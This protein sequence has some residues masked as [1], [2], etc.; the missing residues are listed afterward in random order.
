MPTCP[1]VRIHAHTSPCL[2]YFHA[3]C[4]SMPSVLPCL[5]YFHAFCTSM[6]SVPPRLHAKRAHTRLPCLPYPRV[7]T[8]VYIPACLHAFHA[9]MPTPTRWHTR[10][11]V[12]MPSLPPF[13]YAHPSS[14]TPAFLH[15]FYTSMPPCPHLDT[16][17]CTPLCLPYLHAYI[18]MRLHALTCPY[19]FHPSIRIC[20]HVAI[21][22]STPLCLHTTRRHA[23]LHASIPSML[24]CLHAHTSPYLPYL[25]AM[26]PCT[27][28]RLPAQD[29]AHA[30]HSSHNIIDYGILS[31]VFG[32]RTNTYICAYHFV[33]RCCGG[34]VGSRCFGN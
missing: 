30:L 12:S 18:P 17:A 5:L 1:H 10:L 28:G 7:H 11:H 25:H 23:L 14:H 13:P 20:P 22:A 9:Y 8:L 32:L 34:Q 15:T 24:L 6:P 29:T 4:T 27:P 19:A 26:S 21:H 33:R 3:F 31:K 16:H 2:L